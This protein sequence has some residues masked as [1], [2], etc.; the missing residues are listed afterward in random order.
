MDALVGRYVIGPRRFFLRPVQ[1]TSLCRIRSDLL[2]GYFS[3]SEHHIT[4]LLVN[5]SALLS[6][7]GL[8]TC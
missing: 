7:S 4:S 5:G 2:L 8:K 1:G 6:A 3:F